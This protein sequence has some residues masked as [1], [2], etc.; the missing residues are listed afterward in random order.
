MFFGAKLE[1]KFI[2][3]SAV[4]RIPV[5]RLWQ[6][7][8]KMKFHKDIKQKQNV[9]AVHVSTLREREMIRCLSEE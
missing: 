1:S 3:A 2:R 6:C 9:F 8:V 4:F 7:S 5:F